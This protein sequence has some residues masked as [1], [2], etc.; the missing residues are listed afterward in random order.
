MIHSPAPNKV[1]IHSLTRAG[2]LVNPD[3][4]DSESITL[5]YESVSRISIKPAKGASDTGRPS[6]VRLSP[7]KGESDSALESVWL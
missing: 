7:R 2:L 6:I 4:S 3:Q 1:V 5:A